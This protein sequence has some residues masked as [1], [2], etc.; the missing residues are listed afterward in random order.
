MVQGGLLHSP[1]DQ[2]LTNELFQ[3][4]ELCVRPSRDVTRFRAYKRIIVILWNL[5]HKM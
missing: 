5:I 1:P 2:L 3:Y 4:I